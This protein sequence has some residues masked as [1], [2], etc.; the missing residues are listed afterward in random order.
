[1]HK[2]P[3]L[4]ASWT[5]YGEESF[6][7]S[8][9]EYVEAACCLLDVET[10][11]IQKEQAFDRNYGFNI[12]PTGFSRLGLSHSPET[13]EKM[14][15]AKRGNKSR[16]GKP[17]TQE[18]KL[19]MSKA[20]RGKAI[21]AEQREKIS[22]A[23]TGRKLPAT[24]GQKV[25]AALRGR[26]KPEGFGA[27]VAMAKAFFTATQVLEVRA[28]SASG[29]SYRTIARQFGTSHNVVSKAANGKGPF[30]SNV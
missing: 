17:H 6:S 14:S 26:K 13:I 27:A 23:L 4:Q 7:F 1:V 28:M 21:S 12:Q 15:V 16:L 25:S 29:I 19:K 30:Y 3:H 11:Y 20:Q 18:T 22:A 8:V 5:K 2:N 9:V 24:T 10:S